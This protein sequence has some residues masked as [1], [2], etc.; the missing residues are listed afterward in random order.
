VGYLGVLYPGK[1]APDTSASSSMRCSNIRF[2]AWGAWARIRLSGHG[3]AAAVQQA[4]GMEDAG[5]PLISRLMTRI[6]Y[7][8]TPSMDRSGFVDL[9]SIGYGSG[10]GT[11][12]DDRWIGYPTAG[13]GYRFESV[14]F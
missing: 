13:I 10:A 14:G 11:L 9:G 5:A 6:R 12:M 2:C 8:H 3:A 7:R 4:G 1:K